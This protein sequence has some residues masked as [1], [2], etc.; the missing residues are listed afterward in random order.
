MLGKSATSL[1]PALAISLTVTV[2]SLLYYLFVFRKRKNFVSVCKVEKLFI[3][4]I[5]GVKG[6][7]VDRLEITGDVVKYGRFRDRSVIG[8]HWALNILYYICFYSDIASKFRRVSEPLN[9]QLIICLN[10][11]RAF[12]ATISLIICIA[13]HE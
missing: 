4:P 10:N 1:S 13:I 6:V 11:D 8:S 12:D 2:T 9:Y 5:K 3:Y 7:Q